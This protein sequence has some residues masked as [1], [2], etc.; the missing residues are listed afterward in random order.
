[1]ENR[2]RIKVDIAKNS[3][4]GEQTARYKEGDINSSILE[5]EV[6]DNGAA[7][8]LRDYEVTLIFLTPAARL[9]GHDD[10]TTIS[11]NIITYVLSTELNVAGT[12]KVEVKLS[13]NDE[14][15]S[16]SI[17]NI[18]VEKTLANLNELAYRDRQLPL[19]ARMLNNGGQDGADGKNAYEMAQDDGFTG[20][21]EEWKES[22]K[23]EKGEPG[24]D[25]EF[26]SGGAVGNVLVKTTDGVAW[27]ENT[28]GGGVV[29]TPLLNV[30][31]TLYARVGSK[32]EL[33]FDNVIHSKAG[34]KY[35]IIVKTMAGKQN[36]ESYS[37]TP[38]E[39]H[40][41]NHTVS[42]R[43]HKGVNEVL[44][45]ECTLQIREP[46]DI[47]CRVLT[48][49]DSTVASGR[50]TYNLRD[51]LP[52]ITLVGTR[53]NDNNVHEG[54]GG[55]TIETYATEQTF[56][57]N[58]NKF[59]NPTTDLF[60]YNYY[61]ETY[62]GEADVVIF[63]LGINDGLYEYYMSDE[64][65]EELR[66]RY[67]NMISSVLSYNDD[68]K[69]I[70]CLTTT[71]NSSQQWFGD[72]NQCNQQQ[73]VH[74]HNVYM[75]ANKVIKYYEENPDERV[76]L[77][78]TNAALDPSAHIADNVHPNEAGY[79]LMAESIANYMIN[80]APKE[81][82][83]EITVKT[84]TLERDTLTIDAEGTDPDAQFA[85]KFYKKKT[86]GGLDKMHETGWQPKGVKSE[87]YTVTESGEYIGYVAMYNFVTTEFKESYTTGGYITIAI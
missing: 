78:D 41:G 74:K 54:I 79:R 76:I 2:H 85:F 39:N 7:V 37:F 64:R 45:K 16:S 20:T 8:S 70:V 11:G 27:A 38:N 77:I 36:Q 48:I 73:V 56:N 6:T 43:V 31:K 63:H 86:G 3:V 80:Y 87:S 68:V 72:V 32:K 24:N 49:G 30:P 4:V 82:P 51:I 17:F 62:G 23:G 12:V 81:L 50:I 5:I 35:D 26:P 65:A 53:G 57:D 60:S 15:T 14:I 61:V 33:F 66:L 40:A 67:N 21:Y 29:D 28:G 44:R 83:Y 69:V 1:M 22:L 58:T 59:Y 47:S 46:K 19:I 71:P 9:I 52:N 25:A 42:F 34:E 10:M 75:I 13:Q 84:L 18:L 55:I